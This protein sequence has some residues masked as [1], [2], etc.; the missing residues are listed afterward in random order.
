MLEAISLSEH[1]VALL[2]FRVKKWPT[3][4]SIAP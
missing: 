2:R 4:V 1:A 3:K